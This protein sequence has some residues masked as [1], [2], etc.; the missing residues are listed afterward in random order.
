MPAIGVEE[1]HATQSL[2][3][4]PQRIA[5]YADG[6]QPPE[7]SGTFS[8]TPEDSCQAAGAIIHAN[9]PLRAIGH[10]QLIRRANCHASDLRERQPGIERISDVRD[11]SGS[12]YL[13][14]LTDH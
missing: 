1:N 3:D 4:R 2:V 10:I 13:L 7:L 11:E 6:R 9:A 14:D 5:Q 8:G 12:R